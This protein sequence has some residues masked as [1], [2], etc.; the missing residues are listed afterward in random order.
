M[1]LVVKNPSANAGDVSDAGLIP[2]SERFPEKGMAIHSSTLA[3]RIPWTEEHGMLQSTGL[4]RVESDTTG[5]TW[6]THAV[7]VHYLLRCKSFSATQKTSPHCH[8]GHCCL[9]LEGMPC[10]KLNLH[11]S[12]FFTGRVPMYRNRLTVPM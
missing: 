1:T 11:S 5:V 4:H 6:H 8:N 10:Q 2:G 12:L 9:S 3:W 7:M